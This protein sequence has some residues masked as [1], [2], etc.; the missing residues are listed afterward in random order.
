MD[1]REQARS[2]QWWAVGAI[3]RDELGRHR[4]CSILDRFLALHGR[5]SMLTAGQG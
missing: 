4:Y 5:R 3:P 1:G 2:L